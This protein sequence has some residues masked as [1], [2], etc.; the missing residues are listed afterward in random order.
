MAWLNSKDGY[1]GLTKILHWSI[2]LLFAWQYLA[3]HTM[4]R[5]TP[6]T[7][8]LGLGQNDWYN[9]HK[10]IGLVALFIAVGRLWCRSAGRL[11]DWAPTLGPGEK[12]FIRRAEQILYAAMLVMP[13]S[14]YVY[15]MAGDYGVRLFGMTDL[16]NPLGRIEWLAVTARW[17]HIL[18]GYVL[19]ATVL[20]HVG[21]VLHHHLVLGDGL[22]HRMLPRIRR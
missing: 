19:A 7:G 22:L 17:T 6:E 18:S 5:L 2:A 16:A 8:A 9:W 21:L 1:G 13:V 12:A 14:G 4:V 3:G 15:V 20:G 11:P 10:S